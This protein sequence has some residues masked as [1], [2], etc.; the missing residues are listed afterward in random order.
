M[1][2][3]K[4]AMI[5]AEEQFWNENTPDLSMDELIREDVFFRYGVDLDSA[6]SLQNLMALTPPTE[7]LYLTHPEIYDLWWNIFLANDDSQHDGQLELW[8]GQHYG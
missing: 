5:Q 4:D 8:E 7:A 3:L 6:R 2:K 1:G